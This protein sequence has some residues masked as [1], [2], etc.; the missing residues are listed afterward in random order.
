MIDS[1]Q[2]EKYIL[3]YVVYILTTVGI[4]NFLIFTILTFHVW[5]FF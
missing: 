3:P 4:E 1:F 2:I 5:D